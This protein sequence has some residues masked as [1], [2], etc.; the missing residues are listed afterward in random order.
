MMLN[1]KHTAISRFELPCN[2]ATYADVRK[3]CQLSYC[4]IGIL[5]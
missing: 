3:E 4:M 1:S 5:Q 2:D